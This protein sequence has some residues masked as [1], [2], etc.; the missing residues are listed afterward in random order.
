MRLTLSLKEVKNLAYVIGRCATCTVLVNLWNDIERYSSNN[1]TTN[2]TIHMYSSKNKHK[3]KNPIMFNDIS[4]ILTLD[5]KAFDFINSILSI[6][7][8]DL[9]EDTS[10]PSGLIFNIKSKVKKPLP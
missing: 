7:G 5:N 1:P 6:V 8:L 4:M 2:S 9:L 10:N 3:L